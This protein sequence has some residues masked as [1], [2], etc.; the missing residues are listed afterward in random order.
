MANLDSLI[1]TDQLKTTLLK[2]FQPGNQHPLFDALMILLVPPETETVVHYVDQHVGLLY[3][4]DNLEI[5]GLQ[6]EAFERSFLSQHDTVRRVWRL[7]DAGDI[8]LAFQKVTP[9]VA[10]EVARAA[11]KVLGKTG[12]ELA[13]A[14]AFTYAA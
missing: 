7:S 13:R 3:T 8:I 11:E 12:Q 9:K 14:V 4:P 1:S 10:Q 6:V 2:T 5:V